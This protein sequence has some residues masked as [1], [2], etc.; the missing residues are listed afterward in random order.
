MPVVNLTGI[1]ISDG[2]LSLNVGDTKTLSILFTPSNASD[3]TT[4]FTSSDS[5]I[6]SVDNSGVVT[7]IAPGTATISASSNGISDQINVTV[8]GG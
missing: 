4:T 7:A 2:D 3:K 6:V 1:K 8:I 5:N